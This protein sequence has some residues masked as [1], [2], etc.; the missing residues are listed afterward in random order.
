[1]DSDFYGIADPNEPHDDG[2]LQS[3]LFE[4]ERKGS[5]KVDTIIVDL[6]L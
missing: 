3:K 4:G 5:P 2:R 6:P 1:M